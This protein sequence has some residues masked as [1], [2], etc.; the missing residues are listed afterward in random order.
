MARRRLLFVL[1]LVQI[2]FIEALFFGGGGGSCS[3]APSCP[4]SCPV[5]SPCGSNFYPSGGNSYGGIA[6]YPAQQYSQPSYGFAQQS[7]SYASQPV[8]SYAS[9]PSYGFAQQANSYAS[10]PAS[11]YATSSYSQPQFSAILPP[12][13]SPPSYANSQPAFQQN[14]QAPSASVSSYQ[15][16]PVSLAQPPPE[17]YTE[18]T[19]SPSPYTEQ[20]ISSSVSY[21]EQP[22]VQPTIPST[23]QPYNE[24][25]QTFEP[26]STPEQVTP[27][28][29][30][31]DVDVQPVSATT[32]SPNLEGY[33]NQVTQVDAA[34]PPSTTQQNYRDEDIDY[35]QPT[36]LG[37][38]RKFFIPKHF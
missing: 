26:Q 38:P 10:Q 14:Y 31:L 36:G 19:I 6:N 5:C 11:G 25:T 33:E 24:N 12:L 18:Q 29:G 13:I 17:T 1:V 21:S 34:T 4:T 23:Y 7:S 3:P 27:T 20:T 8:A 9:Q 30:Y 28:R 37:D 2:T 22:I 15:G 16:S 32:Y 35:L